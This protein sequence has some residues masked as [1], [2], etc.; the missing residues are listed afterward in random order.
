[1]FLGYPEDYRGWKLWDPRAKQVIISRDVIWN[2]EEMPGN[3]TAP[4]PLLSVLEYLDQ[5]EDAEPSTNDP[6]ELIKSGYL[7]DLG[8]QQE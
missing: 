3:S 1:V 6:T 4:V 7:S 8:D 2:K 5:E